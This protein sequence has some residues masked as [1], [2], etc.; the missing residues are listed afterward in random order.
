MKLHSHNQTCNCAEQRCELDHAVH[1]EF[2][3]PAA[4][5]PLEGQR[6]DATPQ[7]RKREPDARAERRRITG[8]P[9]SNS[10]RIER[11]S[12]KQDKQSEL[13]HRFHLL[14]A[15]ARVT[16]IGSGIRA[17]SVRAATSCGRLSRGV[18]RNCQ[19]PRDGAAD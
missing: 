11:S 4:H 19:Y 12:G 9:D 15:S 8:N 16:W 18:C 13:G 10:D 6:R 14:M 1:Q 7:K 3:L 17:R 5:E 2:A